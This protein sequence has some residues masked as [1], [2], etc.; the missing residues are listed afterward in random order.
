MDSE[1]FSEVAN[2]SRW[3]IIKYWLLLSKMTNS[4]S[5]RILV[6]C[7]IKKQLVKPRKLSEII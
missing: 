7:A 1:K 6:E 3:L 4:E 5:A 2:Q